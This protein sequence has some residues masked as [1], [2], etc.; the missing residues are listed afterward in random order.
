[1]SVRFGRL[2]DNDT[3]VSELDLIVAMRWLSGLRDAE[4][5]EQEVVEDIVRLLLGKPPI[6]R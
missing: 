3:N 4:L 2:L 5:A 1:M 6:S